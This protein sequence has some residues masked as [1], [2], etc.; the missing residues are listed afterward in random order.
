MDAK[1][2]AQ[3]QRVLEKL[4]KKTKFCLSSYSSLPSFPSVKKSSVFV[5]FPYCELDWATRSLGLTPI[6]DTVLLSSARAGT[7]GR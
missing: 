1:R 5:I 3:R 7:G 4:T 2:D 6:V